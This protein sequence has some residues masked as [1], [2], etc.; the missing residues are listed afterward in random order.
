MTLKR[1]LTP[2]WV[3]PSGISAA[4]TTRSVGN[5]AAHVGDDPAAVILRREQLRRELNLPF[6]V[7][8]LQQQHTTKVSHV[9]A[10]SEPCDAVWSDQPSVCAVLTADCL[11]ILMCTRDGDRIAAVHAGWRGL[12]EGI[13]KSTV[14]AMKVKADQL[15]VWIGPAISQPMFQVG[16]EVRTAFIRRNINAD[17]YFIPDGEGKWLADLSGLATQQ[18]NNLGISDVTLSNR[19]TFRESD[20]WYS[21]RRAQ[22]PA[23]MASLIWRS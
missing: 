4:V 15:S 10:L 18:L 14:T 19:C 22:E 12:V 2:D 11:P 21:W 23:R 3:L 13:I 8:W 17:I 5:L 16:S 7:R 1:I 20:A 9:G 6:H